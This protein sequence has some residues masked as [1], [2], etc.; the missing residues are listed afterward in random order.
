MIIMT[1]TLYIIYALYAGVL[2]YAAVAISLFIT[3]LVLNKNNNFG[4]FAPGMDEYSSMG[5]RYTREV[6]EAPSVEKN[7][8]FSEYGKNPYEQRSHRYPEHLL[9]RNGKDIRE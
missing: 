7:Y 4:D 5:I 9:K 8:L 3:Y 6:N 1:E 2:I